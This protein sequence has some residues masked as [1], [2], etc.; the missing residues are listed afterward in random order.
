MRI[1]INP[2]Y[3]QCVSNIRNFLHRGTLRTGL[4]VFLNCHCQNLFWL[5]ILKRQNSGMSSVEG[6][7]VN[8]RAAAAAAKNCI[9]LNDLYFA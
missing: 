9:T 3:N 7:V 5:G 1:S 2:S 6:M 4:S 8:D